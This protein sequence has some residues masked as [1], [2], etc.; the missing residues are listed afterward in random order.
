MCYVIFLQRGCLACCSVALVLYGGCGDMVDLTALE[1]QFAN[2]QARP[3]MWPDAFQNLGGAFGGAGALL[4]LYD[5]RGALTMVG[6]RS[7]FLDDDVIRDYVEHYQKL[8]PRPQPVLQHTVSSIQYDAQLGS[9]SELDRNP[10]YADFLSRQGLRYFISTTLK[11]DDGLIGVVSVQRTRAAG[12]VEPEQIDWLGSLRAPLHAMIAPALSLLVKGARADALSAVLP[13]L[14]PFG[15]VVSTTG[16][17]LEAGE[18]VY[19]LEGVKRRNGPE[20]RG[21]VLVDAWRDLIMRAGLT[22]CSTG[23]TERIQLPSSVRADGPSSSR[24]KLVAEVRACR[25]PWGLDEVLPVDALV[26][27]LLFAVA[28]VR[29]PDDVTTVLSRE[30]GLTGREV[31]VLMALAEGLLPEEIADHFDL[32]P[33]TI[34][35]HL[36]KAREKTGCHRA[37]QLV[38]LVYQTRLDLM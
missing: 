19:R 7:P 29:R 22:S 24:S 31:D 15:A 30:Y 14:A 11:F 1:T 16:E 27:T 26:G 25:H 18:A 34:R 28:F 37:S 10:F 36:A 35:S 13:Q 23:R 38:R 9:D 32:S 21:C 2:A 20:G 5:K 33:V 4:E 3:G 12:H 8:S 17:V 6:P